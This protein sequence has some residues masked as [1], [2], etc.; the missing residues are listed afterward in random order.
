MLVDL[1]TAR[2]LLTDA[3]PILTPFCAERTVCSRDVLE[4]LVAEAHLVGFVVLPAVGA[5]VRRHRHRPCRSHPRDPGRRQKR[6]R[7]PWRQC[8]FESA[9]VEKQRPSRFFASRDF[10][11]ISEW[12][13]ETRSGRFFLGPK[14]CPTEL[15]VPDERA[16]RAARGARRAARRGCGG[17][18]PM[19][20]RQSES[21]YSD[22]EPYA[23]YSM[24]I[25]YMCTA[26]AWEAS[27][28]VSGK[29]REISAPAAPLA[30][31]SLNFAKLL[32]T[33][34]EVGARADG[35]S[36]SQ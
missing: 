23:P 13:R 6:G 36:Q 15:V 1:A 5:P 8:A 30:N 35:E 28:A 9:F 10:P 25:R 22:R 11:G 7:G 26:C 32:P 20:A 27:G 21:T 2:S 4:E 12:W 34:S 24:L 17:L 16:L 33:P 29:F 31:F 18:G 3:N 19:V 14:W